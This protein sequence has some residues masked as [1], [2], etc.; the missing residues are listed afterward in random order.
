MEYGVNI[1]S[2]APEAMDV[3]MSHS[4]EG[5]VRELKNLMERLVIMAKNDKSQIIDIDLLPEDMIKDRNKSIKEKKNPY[6]L[7]RIIF[8]TEKKII[9]NAMEATGYNKTEAA[10][11]LNIPRSTLYF[12]L[13]KYNISKTSSN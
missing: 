9:L 6:D 5:N 3:L 10:K 12:K 13:E 2:F 1:L 11:L 4:W 8:E 7:N